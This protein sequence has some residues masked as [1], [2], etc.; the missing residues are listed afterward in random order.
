[1]R[2]VSE[3]HKVS[4]EMVSA[5]GHPEYYRNERPIVRPEQVPDEHWYTVE[6]VGDVSGQ[7]VGLRKLITQGELI[8]NVRLWVGESAEIA[9][10]EVTD[11]PVVPGREDAK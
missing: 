4:W 6:R 11:P 5:V 3:A 2:G 7:Y 8:R 10:R 1:M 9:W